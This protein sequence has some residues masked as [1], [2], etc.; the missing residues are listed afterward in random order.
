MMRT[1]RSKWPAS[2]PACRCCGVEAHTVSYAGRGLC[3]GCY[4]TAQKNKDIERYTLVRKP[5]AKEE[6]LTKSKTK[7]K[8]IGDLYDC[9]ANL[10]ATLTATHLETT[11]GQVKRMWEELEEVPTVMRRKASELK[12][13]ILARKREA[14]VLSKQLQA[15]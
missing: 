14:V 2:V 4:M 5:S 6:T 12:V 3:G 11:P 8:A 10:G 7:R 1:I 15:A 9:V 13:H